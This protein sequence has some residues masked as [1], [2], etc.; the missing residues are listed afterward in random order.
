MK[1]GR[2]VLKLPLFYKTL[3]IRKVLNICKILLPLN[4]CSRMYGVNKAHKGKAGG[5][6]LDIKEATIL[7]NINIKA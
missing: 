4:S 2:T 6:I 3:N 5:P 1:T 7:L